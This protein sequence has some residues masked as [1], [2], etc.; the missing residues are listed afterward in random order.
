MLSFLGA[1]VVDAPADMVTAADFDRDGLPEFVLGRRSSPDLV[2]CADGAA[3]SNQRRRGIHLSSRPVALAAADFNSDGIPELA[4]A[5]VDARLQMLVPDPD[6]N[7]SVGTSMTL[8]DVARDLDVHIIGARPTLVVATTTRVQV[9]SP[10][11]L[12]RPLRELQPRAVADIEHVAS[13]LV[14][15]ARI[16]KRER[17]VVSLALTGMTAR[18]IGAK[19]FI[20]DRTVETHLAHAYGKLG[21]RSRVELLARL[22]QPLL[23][24]S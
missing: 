23:R 15:A 4:V 13:R 16:T 24:S 2:V 11:E 21:V 6:L 5:L 10:V 22:G 20:A 1:T 9:V 18:E 17:E 14:D 8:P 19:L 12:D 3:E 7:F